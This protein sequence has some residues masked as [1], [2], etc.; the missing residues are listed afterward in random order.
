MRL[1][2]GFHKKKNDEWRVYLSVRKCCELY[3]KKIILIDLIF[4]KIHARDSLLGIRKYKT[5][6]KKSYSN[7]LYLV[8][9]QQNKWKV[10]SSDNAFT[11]LITDVCCEWRFYR[12]I[13]ECLEKICSFNQ[14]VDTLQFSTNTF[15]I[16][17]LQRILKQE[18]SF[19]P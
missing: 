10:L 17:T 11:I 5:V 18:T 8:S 13:E 19:R 4:Q 16:I 2:T 7:H 3:R 1:K 12:E 6:S 9:L 14:N 15:K